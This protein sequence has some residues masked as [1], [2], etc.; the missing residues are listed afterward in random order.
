MSLNISTNTA[1]LR[2]GSYLSK[3]NALLQ[4]SLDRLASGK[5]ISSP[6]DD[7]GSLAV[8][9]KLNAS[10]NRLAG[11]QNNIQN[12]ISF[13]EVQDG[14]LDTVGNIIDRMSELKGLASQDPMK[15]DQ[16]RSSYNNEFKDLQ[17]QLYSISQQGFNGVSL[18]ANYTTEKGGTAQEALFNAAS[19]DLDEDH[20]ITI[21][22]SAAGSAGSKVS[23]HKS[24]LLSAL[25][26]KQDK[27]LAGSD[28][29]NGHWSDVSTAQKADAAYAPDD[30][31]WVTFAATELSGTCLLYTSPSPR[32]G[33]LS[34]MPSSA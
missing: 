7:P 32:D 25:T 16:D 29:T 4:R 8:S 21:Y 10:I 22:T 33:L 23:V 31:E 11:A 19:Q 5:K 20:T 34:R 15:S 27:S 12:A 2:A 9:M 28:T 30:N 26:V 6:V 17:V 24:L 18:F 14:M 1:A 13:L 3:N